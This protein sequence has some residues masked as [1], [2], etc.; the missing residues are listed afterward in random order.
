MTAR[1]LSRT[2]T[3]A[4]LA[5]ALSYIAWRAAHHLPVGNLMTFVITIG[6]AAGAMGLGCVGWRC[7]EEVNRRVQFTFIL[8]LVMLVMFDLSVQ[9]MQHVARRLEA[10]RTLPPH[11]DTRTLAEFIRDARTAGQQVYGYFNPVYWGLPGLTAIARVPS[12]YCSESGTYDLFDT[13]RYGLRNPPALLDDQGFRPRLVLLGDSLMVGCGAQ[14]GETIADHL[15]AEF[16]PATINA[17]VG[18]TGPLQQYAILKEYVAAWK[19]DLVLWCYFEGNDLGNL[20]DE[21]EMPYLRSYWDTEAT[22]DLLHR[23]GEFQQDL[24]RWHEQEL[25]KTVRPLQMT[26]DPKPI[27][28]TW[29]RFV[30]ALTERSIVLHRLHHLGSQLARPR[31]A[32]LTQYLEILERG[33]TLVNGWGGEL[34]IVYLPEMARYVEHLNLQPGSFREAKDELLKRLAREQFSVIDLEQGFRQW[35]VRAMTLYPHGQGTDVHFNVAGNALA[36]QVI[37]RALDAKFARRTPHGGMG[38]ART[39]QWAAR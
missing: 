10:R 8:C 21:R 1:L 28:G 17:A 35:G 24:I 33:R 32:L 23:Q 31:E 25:T 39:E 7:S 38:I 37:M 4:L 18:G 14:N 6:C 11:A 34:V 2:L 9:G 16:E 22:R 19:P 26:P 30:D 5:A 13:D 3:V 36:A 27:P 15:R 29:A 20:K 12:V